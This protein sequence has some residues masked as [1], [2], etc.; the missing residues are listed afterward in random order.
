VSLSEA[1]LLVDIRQRL[2]SPQS[3]D[4]PHTIGVELEL[5]PVH[6]D[7]IARIAARS[8]RRVDR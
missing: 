5:I 4:S 6:D 3:S 8:E 7:A 1:K 2:F